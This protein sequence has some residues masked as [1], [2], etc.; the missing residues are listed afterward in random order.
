MKLVVGLG[1]P[2]DK[3]LRTLHNMGFM[4]GDALLQRLSLKAKTLEC[5]AK[6]AVTNISGQRVVIAFPQTFMNL[7]GESVS[8]LVKKYGCD[9]SEEL[10]VIYDDI[11]LPAGTLRLRTEGSA[12]THNGMRNIVGLLGTEKIKR[13]RIGI[14][15]PPEFMQL[16]DYVL[17]DVPK[18][19]YDIQFK[20]ILRASEAAGSF[21]NG[22]DFESIMREYNVAE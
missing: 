8:S 1:N 7:C 22:A 16:A 6:T 2:G 5:A 4:A 13:I 21:V 9:V 15:K 12:G 17:S 11:D 14:G 10:L 20:A 3:Y 19:L 18:Q